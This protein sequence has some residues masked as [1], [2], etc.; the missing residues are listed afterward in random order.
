MKKTTLIF[1]F[2]L[3]TTLTFG[4]NIP[5]EYFDLVKKPTHFTTQKT[6]GIRQT[7][8]LTHLRQMV[9]KDYQT[10]DIMLLALGHW[11]QFQTVPFFN[12]TELR[13]KQITPITDTFQLTLT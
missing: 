1:A 4:Q 6:L 9:G 8:T 10:T 12:L 3:T 11:Q 5:Q 7:N 13:L 2:F